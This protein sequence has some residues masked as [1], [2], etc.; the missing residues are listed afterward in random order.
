MQVFD[1]ASDVS[2]NAGFDA[3]AHH[4]A[5]LGCTAD[6]VG[7]SADG[8]PIGIESEPR[9]VSL[10]QMTG[11]NTTVFDVHGCGFFGALFTVKSGC[12]GVHPTA[13]AT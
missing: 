6:E 3:A 8:I 2:G 1:L 7:G 5:Q 10:P 11:G 13:R 4:P 9:N 12:A